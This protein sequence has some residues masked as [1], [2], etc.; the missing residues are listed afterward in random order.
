MKLKKSFGFLELQVDYDLGFEKALR[1]VEGSPMRNRKHHRTTKSFG[2]MDGARRRQSRKTTDLVKIVNV[3]RAPDLAHLARPGAGP[4]L[5]T[6][7]Q[8]GTVH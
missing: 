8:Y 4:Y 3:D 5:P 1:T 6:Q 2:A 7:L